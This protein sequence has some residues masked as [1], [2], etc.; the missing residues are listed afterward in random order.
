VLNYIDR[1]IYEVP[2]A[3]WY[4]ASG[5]YAANASGSFPAVIESMGKIVQFE[6][7]VLNFL[8]VPIIHK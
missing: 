7:K 2:R 5:T 3:V 6:M 4:A 1:N 8:N